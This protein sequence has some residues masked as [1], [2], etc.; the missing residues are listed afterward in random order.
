MNFTYMQL[1]SHQNR[2][3]WFTAVQR[4]WSSVVFLNP[5]NQ[6]CLRQAGLRA[7]DIQALGCQWAHVAHPTE[8][9][10]YKH[11][12]YNSYGSTKIL[13]IIRHWFLPEY[14]FKSFVVN[15]GSVLPFFSSS[16]LFF[17]LCRINAA[18]VRLEDR[19][20]WVFPYFFH[21]FSLASTYCLEL[22]L[23]LDI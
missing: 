17:S 8:Y 20:F 16:P 5:V 14:S 10:T 15:F 7:A 1:H 2:L 4:P 3:S 6:R 19:T 18:G 23:G 12:G 21:C 9:A 11:A 13:L 22:K